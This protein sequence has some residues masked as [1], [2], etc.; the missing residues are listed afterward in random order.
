MKRTVQAL[1][2]I[3]DGIKGKRVLEVACGC[4]EFSIEASSIADEI[5]CIDMDSFRLLPEIENHPKV[6]FKQMDATKMIYEDGYFDSCIMY[7][8]IGHLTNYM[9]EIVEECAR[10]T[11]PSSNIY[12]ISSF[13]MD[14][15][16]IYDQ[17]IPLLMSKNMTYSLTEKSPFICV[18]IKQ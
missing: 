7:N 4:A 9:E 1:K 12:V 15:M 18:T 17:L 14:K 11:V 16:V 8:A 5:Q 6:I 3:E 13:K 10:V 2:M